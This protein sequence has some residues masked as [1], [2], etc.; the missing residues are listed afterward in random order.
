MVWF[1]QRDRLSLSLETRYDND[2]AEY[3]V[4]LCHPDGRHQTERFKRQEAFRDWLVALEQTL[5]RDQWKPDGAPHFLPDGWPDKT[6][7]W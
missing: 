4:I 7:F 5:T 1:Y 6:P 2:I 3:V